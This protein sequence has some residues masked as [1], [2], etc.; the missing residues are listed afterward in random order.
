M[1]AKNVYTI[2]LGLLGYTDNADFQRKAVTIINK[3]YFDLHRICNGTKDFEPIKS[4]NEA[5][6]LPDKVLLS[7]M[8]LGVA[9]MLAL[10]EGDGELQQY[11]ANDYDRGKARLNVID[12]IQDVMP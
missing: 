5:L 1:T 8:P 11:F 10:G 4:L 3:V 7:V 12:T 6:S 9:E 2:A